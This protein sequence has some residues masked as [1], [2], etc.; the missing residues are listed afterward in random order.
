[1]KSIFLFIFFIPLILTAQSALN[2]TGRISL[3]TLNNAYSEKSD[4]KPDSI[5]ADQYAK[6]SLVPGLEER[7]NVAIFAR[8]SKLD[9]TL[10]A[11]VKNNAWDRL[12]RLQRVQRLSLSA[13]FGRSEIVLG[14]FFE[15]G[16]EFFVQSREVRGARADL[17]FARL[18]NR[19]SYLQTRFSGGLVQKAYSVGDRLAGLYHQYENAGQYRRYFGSAIIRLADEQRFELALKY[20]L[21][22]DDTASVDQAINEPLSNQNMGASGS[23]YL[24]DKRIQFFGEGY[25]S[26]K[27]TLSAQN[28]NDHAYKGGLDFR[29]KQFKLIVFY[30]RLG[31]D[32]YSAGYPFLQNDRQGF[33]FTSAWNFPGTITL[34]AEGEQYKDNL[35][36]DDTRPTTQT[37]LAEA[38]FTTHF[39]HWPEFTLKGRFRDDNSDTILDTIKTEK[40]SRGLEAGLA[41]S[42]GNQRL[43]FSTFLIDLDD[44]SVLASGSP[45]GTRQLISSLNFYTRPAPSLFIS[46][47]GV[48]S[49]LELTNNQENKNIYAYLSGRWDLFKRKVKLEWSFN[50]IINDAENG[51]N[52]DLLSDY[53]Q[54]GSEV[55]LEYFFNNSISLKLIGGNDRRVMGYTQQQALQVIA[56][57][58]YGPLFFNGYETYNSLKFGAEVNWIF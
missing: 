3:R 27:D 36:K 6:S 42:F 47:G 37:R 1:M 14:D 50:Y 34:T 26:R 23:L 41:Y 51:G 19:S 28:I 17:R 16:S 32:Y 56:D 39:K 46:G 53:N 22:R 11:D 9:M 38:G 24:W 20:L 45:L 8:T 12:D 35:N 10:L 13:R 40:I 33:K 57:P 55:S 15:S 5:A 21:A 31:Y 29:L 58:N 44:H 4:I 48:Y 43:S 25:M 54:L 49:T 7:M 52:Q 30:Q 18:W 2:I